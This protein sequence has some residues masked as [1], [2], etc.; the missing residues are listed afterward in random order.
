MVP[1][2]F[3]G[4]IRRTAPFSCLLRHTTGC[5]G[6]ILTRILG[7]NFFEKFQCIF[8]LLLLSPLGEGLS[9]SFGETW[10]LIACGWFVQGLVE[11]GPLVLEKKIFKWP[12]PIFL[13]FCDY[14]PFEED[15]TIYLNKLE[16]PLPENNL[17]QVWLN[18]ASCFGR[19]RS[20]KNFSA[21]LLFRYYLPLEKSYPIPLN[22]L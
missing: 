6:S 2:L 13:F 9:P 1:R 10:I 8:T 21:F 12:H 5:G 14:L 22:T 20:L 16:F 7:S 17:Y 11:I 19:T 3:S 18:L 4:L 15:L